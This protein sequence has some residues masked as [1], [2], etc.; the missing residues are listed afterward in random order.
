MD[1]Y[2]THRYFVCACFFLNLIAC[3]KPIRNYFSFSPVPSAVLICLIWTI[4]GTFLALN[5][6]ATLNQPTAQLVTEQWT[7][8]RWTA[9]RINVGTLCVTDSCYSVYCVKTVGTWNCW[10]WLH[11][12]GVTL[13]KFYVVRWT[14]PP[15]ILCF[16]NIYCCARTASVTLLRVT[17]T[18]NSFLEIQEEFLR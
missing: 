10:L 7:W 1:K 16:W 18:L 12:L 14:N 6:G 2:K 13:R 15:Q 4:Q 11:G 17:R 8:C 3:C 9:Q 5:A